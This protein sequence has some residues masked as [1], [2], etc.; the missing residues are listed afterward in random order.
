MPTYIIDQHGISE[1]ESG[2]SPAE[3][4][5]RPPLMQ[6][7]EDLI[8][9]H[10][11]AG[12]RMMAIGTYF[13]VRGY[14]G[15]GR[16][17]YRRADR[18]RSHGGRVIDFMVEAGIQPDLGAVEAAEADFGGAAAAAAQALEIELE[19]AGKIQALDEKAAAEDD[20]LTHAFLGKF[21]SRQL[22]GVADMTTLLEV[23]EHAGDSLILAEE[24]AR[25]TVD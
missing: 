16:L 12:H 6:P 19:L 22:E 8:T 2:G 11:S 15:L 10:F 5:V 7:L 9:D 25:R 13:A 18:L 21:H 20:Y 17:F 1:E 3:G 4:L 24:H 14:R 23:M